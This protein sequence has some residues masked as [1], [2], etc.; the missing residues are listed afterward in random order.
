M[1]KGKEPNIYHRKYFIPVIC[2]NCGNVYFISA[3]KG[4]PQPKG[5]FPV[6]HRTAFTCSKPCSQKV[7]RMN[8]KLRKKIKH[9]HKQIT[10]EQYDEK[11]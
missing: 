1:N 2:C 6:R 7:H 9:N 11:K 10:W 3:T 4:N 5:L 8:V